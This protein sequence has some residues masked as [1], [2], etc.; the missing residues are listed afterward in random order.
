MGLSSQEQTTSMFWWE[1]LFLWLANVTHDMFWFLISYI[2]ISAENPS[3]NVDTHM[4]LH[5]IKYAQINTFTGTSDK[6]FF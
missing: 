3:L 5:A 6:C 4:I 1:F 2:L